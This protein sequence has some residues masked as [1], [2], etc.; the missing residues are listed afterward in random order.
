MRFHIPT[1]I[2]IQAH[3]HR[4]VRLTGAAYVWII[5]SFYDPHWWQLSDEQIS[6]L[7]SSQRC[8]NYEI[9][10]IFNRTHVLSA[11]LYNYQLKSVDDWRNQT[12]NIVCDTVFHEVK[13]TSTNIQCIVKQK[14][15]LLDS[16]DVITV[17]LV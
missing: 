5:P 10:E 9:E 14:P 1:Y 13:S 17:C 3:N 2:S 8:S 16:N 11:A 4:T 15:G 7:P 6:Q 12:V